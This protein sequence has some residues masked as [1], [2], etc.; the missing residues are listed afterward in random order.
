MASTGNRFR[1]S[2]TL[3]RVARESLRIAADA[4]SLRPGHTEAAWSLSQGTYRQDRTGARLVRAVKRRAAKRRRGGRLDVYTDQ[5][6]FR[7][8][9]LVESIPAGF[10]LWSPAQF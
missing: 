4:R 1:R 3:P 7:Q 9:D 8:P 5:P 2:S 6:Y 10:L